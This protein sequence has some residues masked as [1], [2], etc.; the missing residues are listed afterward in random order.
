MH[1]LFLSATEIRGGWATQAIQGNF[2]PGVKE[3]N[4][5][6]T[7]W[8]RQGDGRIWKNRLQNYLGI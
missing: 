5:I 8:K 2:P 1:V 6:C 3:R 7:L 4:C